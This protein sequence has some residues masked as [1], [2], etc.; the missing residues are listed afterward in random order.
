MEEKLQSENFRDKFEN[1]DIYISKIDVER[2]DNVIDEAFPRNTP[3]TGVWHNT[4]VH[5]Y[6]PLEKE[7][8]GKIFLML[9]NQTNGSKSALWVDVQFLVSANN[10]STSSMIC[11]FIQY[12]F[13]WTIK[14]V[15]K[16]N[17]IDINGSHFLVP[18]FLYSREQF[19][20][21]FPD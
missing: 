17:V 4:N 11:K 2:I 13:D 14:Y 20:N 16:Y 10:D 7:I 6:K 5:F 3:F 8:V 9:K 18:E 21:S 19:I 1:L 12:L 15:E